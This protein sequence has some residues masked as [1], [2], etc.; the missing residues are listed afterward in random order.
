MN[1]LRNKTCIPCSEGVA[2]MAPGDIKE[3]LEKIPEWEVATDDGI[4]RLQRTFSF[5]D[6]KSAIA[7]TNKVGELAEVEQHHPKLVTE[8]GKVTVVWW[9]HS[10]KGLHKNDFFMAAKTSE[11]HAD[12]QL[13][14]LVYT[15]I[16]FILSSKSNPS[17]RELAHEDI[18]TESQQHIP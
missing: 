9:T 8:W 13:R 16:P 4:S 6:F 2:S 15:V 3:L 5:K 14:D 18:Y 17:S 12:E 10:V 11:L 1:K 7:F